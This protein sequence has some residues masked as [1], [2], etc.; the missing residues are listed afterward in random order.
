MEDAGITALFGLEWFAWFCTGG[1]LWCV[2]DDDAGGCL[3]IGVGG[4][5][6]L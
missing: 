4:G 1:S 5:S 2:G 6:T 3:G